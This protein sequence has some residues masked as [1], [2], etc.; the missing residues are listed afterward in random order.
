M[1]TG[2]SAADRK[3]LG[4]ALAASV[5]FA[6]LAGSLAPP[7]AERTAVPSS[8]SPAPG[9]ALAGYLLLQNLHY[10][11]LRWTEPPA[12]LPNRAADAVLILAEPSQ[13][14]T[15]AERARVIAFVNQG[16]RVLFCGPRV[17]E[18][19]PGV[20]LEPVLKRAAAVGAVSPEFPSPFTRGVRKLAL[21]PKAILRNARPGQISL[22]GVDGKPVVAVWPIGKGELLWW[23]SAGPL[24]NSDIKEADN[25]ALLV[26][27]VS[28]L[29]SSHSPRTIIWDEYFHGVRGSL[30]S[31][32]E[33]TPVKWGLVQC[34]ILALAALFAF[35]RRSGPL[36]PPRPAS[37]LS[38]LEFVE[39]LGGLYQRAGVTSVPAGIAY[40]HLR[41]RLARRLQLPSAS[42]DST[43]T[44]AAQQ[45]LGWEPADFASTL[46]RAQAAQTKNVRAAEALTIV[47]S[48]GYY[49]DRLEN[50][51]TSK[52]T[53]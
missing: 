49:L 28:P 29:T 40:R 18:F 11:V 37:R 10:P 45:R 7:E 41:L 33:T 13:E 24:T 46:T 34:A 20:L 5:I 52:E 8:Y 23:A 44:L 43:L 15:P 1:Q 51:R 22:A 19:F 21:V 48:I 35:S 32:V 4:G 17:Q 14:P 2:L 42:N 16:G 47:Q 12:R 9:G 3:L 53:R 38:P 30:W 26:S 31:Y 50:R 27:A 6:A 36:A 39:T 25:V